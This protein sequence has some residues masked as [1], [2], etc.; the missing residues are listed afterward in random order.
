[1]TDNLT[2]SPLQGM[3]VGLSNPF[4]TSIVFFSDSDGTAIKFKHSG[5]IEIGEAWGENMTDAARAL[6]EELVRV[7]PAIIADRDARIEAQAAEIEQ[8]REALRP[9]ATAAEKGRA[10]YIGVAMAMK[11]K[12]ELFPYSTAYVDAG[13]T[14]ASS[15]LTWNDYD[16]ARITFFAERDTGQPWLRT[17][18]AH[19]KGTNNA[20]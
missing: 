6:V 13:R 19:L 10:V 4:P 17:Y 16:D 5:E 11:E 3:N 7:F 1:M 14:T 12:P 20:E 18:D 15:H 8:L 2:L 9:F